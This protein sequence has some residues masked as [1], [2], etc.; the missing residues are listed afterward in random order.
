[1][2]ELVDKLKLDYNLIF[3]CTIWESTD[4]C[5]KQYR[6]GTIQYV[7]RILHLNTAL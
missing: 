1:M 4:W 5:S 2:I 6:C 3:F 7:C